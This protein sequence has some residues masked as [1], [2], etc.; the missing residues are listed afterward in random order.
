MA[1]G[2]MASLLFFLGGCQV[3]F[4]ADGASANSSSLVRYVHIPS[5]GDRTA[6]GG[7]SWRLTQA[8]HL[9]SLQHTQLR[10][11]SLDD[12][13]VAVDLQV[14]QVS[15]VVNEVSECDPKDDAFESAQI[16]SAAYRCNT[17]KYSV[18]QAEVTSEKETLKAE[19]MAHAIDLKTGKTLFQ[20]TLRA[21][22]GTFDVVGD[23]TVNGNLT[24]RPELHAVRYLDNR[25]RARNTVAQTLA[26]RV[27][28]LLLSTTWPR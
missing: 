21:A 9:K 28:S 1:H 4:V 20:K 2:L 13:R 8:V 18:E 17:I 22:S 24:D 15:W 26:E 6:H 23:S 10:T 16:G 3:T 27:T 14:T 19:I 5:A 25:D 12:A 7:L 11:S